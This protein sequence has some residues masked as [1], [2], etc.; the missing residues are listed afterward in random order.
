MFILL[1]LYTNVL[2]TVEY[3]IVELIVTGINL[4]APILT[5]S[6]TDAI[7]RFGLDKNI[8]PG[9]VLRASLQFMLIPFTILI[10]CTPLIEFYKPLQGYSWFLT[11]TL[12][13]F[14]F[15]STTSFFLKSIDKN[16]MFAIDTILY[17]LT[18][19]LANILFLLT[20]GMGISGY[21]LSLIV[22]S[23]ISIVFCCI[24][25]RIPRYIVKSK[26]DKVLLKKMLIYSVPL[27]LNALSWWIINSSD[28]Y[29][30]EYYMSE[31]E[32]G[33]YSVAAKIPALLSAFSSLFGQAWTI[34]SVKEY[35]STADRSFYYNIFK[36]FA[37]AMCISTC[38]L[39]LIIKPFMMV[40]VG[41][42]FK[43]SWQ[44]V[45]ILLISALFGSLSSFF[46]AMYVATRQNIKC[47]TSTLI[48]AITNIILNFLL[49]PRFG[50]MGATTATAIAYIVIGIYRM[51][52]CQKTFYFKID[53]LKHGIAVFLII[54]QAIVVIVCDNSLRYIVSV[55][56]F[57]ILLIVYKND[58][59]DLI[60]FF[61][62]K[63]IG[64]RKVN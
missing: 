57:G 38:A 34:S 30:L 11:I 23:I 21:M 7:L 51:L 54:L 19:A 64:K 22:A 5:L 6:I 3:G 53:Y 42:N 52:D 43:D 63:L 58:I 26:F 35:D 17:T 28:K 60:D 36:M 50:I 46:G 9:K 32:V 10:I 39:L 12:I 29:M 61:L 59:K 37:T 2:S 8:E 45:P 20:W 18:L 31:Y 49:I 4:L 27:I 44:Y 24:V 47:T 13:V 15:R 55:T 33:I 14:S 41:V 1:P 16:L 62:E 56:I 40:Y 48:C 25:G